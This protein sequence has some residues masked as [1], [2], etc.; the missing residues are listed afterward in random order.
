MLIL[1]GFCGLRYHTST[2]IKALMMVE[3]SCG[4]STSEY[5]NRDV[6][7]SLF[8]VPEI[9]AYGTREGSK[10]PIPEGGYAL[11]REMF[12]GNGENS[13]R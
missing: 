3:S 5:Q 4:N 7:A 9:L 8:D 2:L 13:Y 11:F 12:D 10:Y 6:M 1:L